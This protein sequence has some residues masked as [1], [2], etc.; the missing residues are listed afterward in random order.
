M[1]GDVADLVLAESARFQFQDA[2]VGQCPILQWW[3]CFTISRRRGQPAQFA[4]PVQSPQRRPRPLP[5]AKLRMLYNLPK[6]VPVALADRGR[7]GME[8]GVRI[9]PAQEAQRLRLPQLRDVDFM[10]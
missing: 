1:T 7:A 8:R 4:E 10:P 6:L 5:V 9:C 3:R 2:V